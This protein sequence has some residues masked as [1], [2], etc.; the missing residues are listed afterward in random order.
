MSDYQDREDYC[1][2]INAVRGGEVFRGK[3]SNQVR[4]VQVRPGPRQL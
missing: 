4:E 1:I 3:G 2:N